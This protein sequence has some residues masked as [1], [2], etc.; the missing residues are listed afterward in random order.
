MAAPVDAG[1]TSMRAGADLGS[2]DT[3]KHTTGA[4]PRGSVAVDDDAPPPERPAAARDPLQVIASPPLPP[5]LLASQ[6][7]RD[8]AAPLEPWSRALRKAS[9]A[10]TLALV[11]LAAIDGARGSLG[12]AALIA[13]AAAPAAHAGLAARYHARGASALVGGGVAL[14]LAA[15][16]APTPAAALIALAIAAAV[17]A[18]LFFRA[19]YR[20]SRGA[21]LVLAAALIAAVGCTLAA[22]PFARDTS[23]FE[24]AIGCVD[25]VLA[26]LAALGFMGEESTGGCLAWGALALV[27]GAASAFAAATAHGASSAAA[28]QIATLGLVGAALLAIGAVQLAAH[29]FAP[30]LRACIDARG[31]RRAPSATR[32]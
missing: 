20:A 25:L 26:A 14:V 9:L 29:R 7:L 21:R 23:T 12:L 31:R 11:T 15:A 2:D 5:P 16:R 30:G 6:C 1:S 4:R 17:G 3:H 10:A 22:A 27:A 32:A 19:I 18:T 24:R 13:L 28:F 8:D